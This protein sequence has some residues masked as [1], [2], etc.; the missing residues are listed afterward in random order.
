MMSTDPLNDDRNFVVSYYLADDQISVYERRLRNS[1]FQS[2]LFFGKRE[3][4]KPDQ[5]RFVSRKPDIYTKEDFWIGNTLKLE[6]YT[7]ELLDADDYCMRY[8][9]LNCHE[10][11]S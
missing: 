1:G 11:I 5:E 3:I 10:V 6:G 9:E 7:F 8:M 2:Q 4:F